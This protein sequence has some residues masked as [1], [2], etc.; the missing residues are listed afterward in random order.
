MDLLSLVFFAPCQSAR[1]PPQGVDV[2]S[3]AGDSRGPSLSEVD[4]GA[5]HSS[6]WSESAAGCSPGRIEG[7]T[8]PKDR[9]L[10]ADV[11]IAKEAVV[12]AEGKLALEEEEVRKGEAVSCPA[13]RGEPFVFPTSHCFHKF[14][15]GVQQAPEFRPRTPAREGRLRAELAGHAEFAE[16]H[17]RKSNRSLSTLSPFG[18]FD[19]S[20]ETD[21]GQIDFGHP[22]FPTLAKPTLAR[23]F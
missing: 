9:I 21:F 6:K 10:G 18:D 23:K 5:A 17:P 8:G 22:Y 13:A 11:E 2:C 19:A 20:A 16:G 1:H 12:N 14:R 3:F 7:R 15:A 4:E